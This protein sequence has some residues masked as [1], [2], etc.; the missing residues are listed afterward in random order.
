M[1]QNEDIK[2]E[3]A[4]SAKDFADPET[5]VQTPLPRAVKLKR[6]H[7]TA[8]CVLI[9]GILGLFLNVVAR[10]GTFPVISMFIAAT[11][12]ILAVSVSTKFLTGAHHEK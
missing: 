9:L 1:T 7:V 5:P 6:L 11:G 8:V 2:N 10:P 3:K 4:V 12:I